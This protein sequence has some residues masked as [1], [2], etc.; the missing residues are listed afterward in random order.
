MQ[1][2]ILHVGPQ[3]HIHLLLLLPNVSRCQLHRWFEDFD[4]SVFLDF[5]SWWI[6]ARSMESPRLASKISELWGPRVVLNR[7]GATHDDSQGLHKKTEINKHSHTV[8]ENHRKSLIRHCE[9]SE[10]RSP[11]ECLWSNSITILVNFDSTK[12]GGKCQN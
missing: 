1:K 10:Q 6:W 7:G 8:F 4:F 3:F 12:I 5:V 2:C 9:R 11:F